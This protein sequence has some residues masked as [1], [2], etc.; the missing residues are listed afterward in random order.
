[1]AEHPSDDPLLGTHSAAKHLGVS[2]SRV[3][4]YRHRGEQPLPDADEVIDG[5]PFW[6]R[7]TLDRWDRT[8][9]YLPRGRRRRGDREASDGSEAGS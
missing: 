6:R 7:S 9:R 5:R 8:E 3:W 4:Q 2:P 1:V